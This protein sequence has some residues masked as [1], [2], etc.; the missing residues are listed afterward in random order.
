VPTYYGIKILNPNAI[1]N[2]D[3][4][5]N[6]FLGAVFPTKTISLDP[7]LT[8]GRRFT[9]DALGEW[10]LGGHNLNA[11]GYVNSNLQ[12]WQP[13]YAAQA[14]MKA[15]AA[16][17]TTAMDNVTALERAKC[18]LSGTARDLSYWVESANFFKLRSVSVTYDLPPR[19]LFGWQSASV[20][21]AGR[22]LFTSTSYDG[23]DPEVSDQTD[24]QFGRRDYYVFPQFRTFLLT[25]RVGF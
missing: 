11:V 12:D 25:V 6:Q 5:G 4:A 21:L 1:A 14:A 20:S 2:P 10:Q 17:N 19:R 9:V 15:F 3:T 23:T 22:N 18:T 8:L 13:C 24:N 7:T 16:G